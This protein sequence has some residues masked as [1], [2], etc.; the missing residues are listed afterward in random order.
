MTPSLVE[1]RKHSTYVEVG[2]ADDD[3]AVMAADL[4]INFT[5]FCKFPK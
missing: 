1:N 4:N 3:T 2:G 5:L